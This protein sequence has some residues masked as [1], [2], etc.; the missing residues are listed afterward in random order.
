MICSANPLNNLE[1][2]LSSTCGGVSFGQSLGCGLGGSKGKCLRNFLRYF[3]H[4]IEFI[5][6]RY[7]FCQAR[8]QHFSTARFWVTFTVYLCCGSIYHRHSVKGQ[9]HP[10]SRQCNFFFLAGFPFLC[11]GGIFLSHPHYWALTVV[12]GNL[13]FL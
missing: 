3:C 11:W 10:C 12:C 13:Q 1:H 5:S 4:N 2:L 8:L 6:F 9:I 7:T